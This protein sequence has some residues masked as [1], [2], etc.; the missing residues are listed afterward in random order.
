MNSTA[1]TRLITTTRLVTL[2]VLALSACGGGE[3]S[4]AEKAYDDCVA[5]AGGDPMAEMECLRV[6]TEAEKGSS[7]DL[8]GVGD[9]ESGPGLAAGEFQAC[10]TGG[11]S[12]SVEP[13]SMLLVVD[14]SS[15]MNN[16]DKWEQASD[17]LVAFLESPETSGL[18]IGLRFY[19]DD[20]SQ[21]GGPEL[22]NRD[23]CSIE[24]CSRPLVESGPLTAASGDADAQEQRLVDAI[25]S[26]NAWGEDGRGTPTYAALGGGLEWG[27]QYQADHPGERAIVILVTDGEPNGCNSDNSAIAGLAG[28]AFR[29]DGI[30]TY[31]IGLEGSQERQMDEIAEAGG[32][33]EGIFIGSANAQQDLLEALTT[34]RGETLDC[35]FDIP[36]P[37]MGELDPNKVNVVLTAGD[38]DEQFS[39]V[40]GAQQCGDDNAWYYQGSDRIVLCPA[41][42]DATLANPNAS[43]SLV[44][45]CTTGQDVIV[46]AR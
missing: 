2:S 24:A 34:I 32:T 8:V 9:E 33:G 41:A 21:E 20:F 16:D 3:K 18:S 10:A 19:P 39:K 5:N 36:D 28:D 31:A 29:Q 14:I 6:K 4:D 25:R 37:D 43:I 12:A 11:A 17:A 45:G 15:S 35:E 40:D 23:D 30:E 1:R 26:T 38:S 42:C 13:A 46:D 22:C 44:F 7:D 27:R